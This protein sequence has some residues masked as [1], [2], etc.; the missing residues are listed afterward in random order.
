LVADDESGGDDK[1][2]RLAPLATKW[3]KSVK[4]AHGEVIV[5]EFPEGS[6]STVLQETAQGLGKKMSR[7]AAELLNEMVGGSYSRG[8]GE[9]EKLASYVGE[10]EEI[11]EEHVRVAVAPNLE[12]NMWALLDAVRER[13]LGM[14]IRQLRILG[15]SNRKLEDTAFQTIFPQLSR[16]LRLLWQAKLCVDHGYQPLNAPPELLSQFLEKPNI[17]SEK[18][19]TLNRIFPQAK[20]VSYRQISACLQELAVAD[21]RIKGALPS[22]S[23]ADTIERLL[24]RIAEILAPNKK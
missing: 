12:W 20:K 5:C 23:S 11:R 15:A 17:V 6:L 8:V 3:Q 4:A 13:Q 10:A 1:A 16:Y 14:A 9:V 7:P 22:A 24:L 19:G 18:P 2:K 21:A